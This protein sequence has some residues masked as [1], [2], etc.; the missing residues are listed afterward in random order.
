M[1][2]SRT[3]MQ[4]HVPTLGAP[5]FKTWSNNTQQVHE[6]TNAFKTQTVF[7]ICCMKTKK[8]FHGMAWGSHWRG[9]RS[10]NL[11]TATRGICFTGGLGSSATTSS[12][13]RRHLCSTPWPLAD[14]QVAT[15]AW[16]RP[17]N[18]W[19]P[20]PRNAHPSTGTLCLEA[21]QSD[22]AKA[23]L[24]V[25]TRAAV[26]CLICT[27]CCVAII[28]RSHVCPTS[29]VGWLIGSGKPVLD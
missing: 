25:P 12:Q 26:P 18:A 3:A 19:K 11:R 2:K 16:C 5:S 8:S 17:L 9:I 20:L 14:V 22:V 21:R 1:L 15:A 6:P 24:K 27:A 13:K 4:K 23:R 10:P 7:K 28:L 29:E